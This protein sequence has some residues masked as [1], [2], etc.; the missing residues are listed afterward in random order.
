VRKRWSMSVLASVSLLLLSA[1]LFAGCGG[2][3]EGKNGAAVDQGET[4]RASY[5]DGFS[6]GQTEGL[7]QGLEDGK[8]GKYE[9]QAPELA[10]A[11]ED[12]L[13]GYIQ[14]WS[15]GYEE[16]YAEGKKQAGLEDDELAEVEAA[17]IAFVKQN[18]APGL[19]FR[20]DNIVIQGDTAVG[21]AVCTSERLESPY[22]VM[23][24]GASGWRGV[25]FGTGIEPPAWYPY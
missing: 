4:A 7:E 23:E 10:G 6:R 20:I 3:G 16:G 9:P 13:R 2:S 24:K 15:E 12:F 5:E 18:S 11:D 22:V 8:A 19:E 21:R 17:M 14:G 1:A 25:D